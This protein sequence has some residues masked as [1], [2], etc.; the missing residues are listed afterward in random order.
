MAAPDR[1]LLE[2]IAWICVGLGPWLT[3]GYLTAHLAHSQALF[4]SLALAA[5]IMWI[6]RLVPDFVPGLALILIVT[7]LDLVPQEIAFSGFYSQVFFLVFGIFILAALLAESSWMNRLEAMLSRRDAS[8]MTRLFAVLGAGVLLT[9]VVPSP[10]GRASMVQP[11]IKRFMQ[12]GLASRN[13]ALALIHM[14]GT[15]LISTIILTGNPLN[16]ILIGMLSEQMRHRYQWLGWL[17]ATSAAGL[18]LSMGLVAAVFLCASLMR[19]KSQATAPSETSV[20]NVTKDALRDWATLAL[21]GVLILAIFTRAIHQIPLEWVV[22]FLAMAVFF[23]AGLSL[24]TLRNNF[25]WP[26]LV[27]IATVVAWGPMLDHLGLS[28]WLA[29]RL[30]AIIPLFEQSL[31][32]GFAVMIA[33]VAI[34]RLAIPGAPAFIILATALLPFAEEIA[35]SPWVLGFVI[36]T[37]SEGFIWPYQHG[38]FS[39]SVTMLDARG[40]AYNMSTFIRFNLFFLALRCAAIFASIPLWKALNLI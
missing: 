2:L 19:K 36:L 1:S 25:D 23:F 5:I 8:F 26:T 40:V 15:T 22:L 30:P 24:A 39:Q 20:R 21:Y 34:I 16:F 10:L 9:L 28:A 37:I 27:F 33:G 14:H 31:Y 7:L 4:L 13:S 38:V 29:E 12:S 3:Y 17:K 6:F 18:V 11:L 35:V 32:L